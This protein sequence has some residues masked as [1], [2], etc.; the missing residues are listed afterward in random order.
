M[1]ILNVIVSSGTIINICL[2][3]DGANEKLFLQLMVVSNN[4]WFFM[5]MVIWV[6]LIKI[7]KKI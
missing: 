5:P 1:I 3:T 4:V 7:P 2:A 6:N